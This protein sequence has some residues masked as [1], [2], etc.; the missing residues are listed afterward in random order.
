MLY[1]RLSLPWK[2]LRS[3]CDEDLRTRTVREMFNRGYETASGIWETRKR[4]IGDLDRE[5]SKRIRFL[6]HIVV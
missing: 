4:L 1:E 5:D 3:A 2:V 6:G